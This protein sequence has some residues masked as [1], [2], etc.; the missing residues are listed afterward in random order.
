MP[1]DAN[2]A[3]WSF[4]YATLSF[5]WIVCN[6]AA[7]ELF[8]IISFYGAT[9]ALQWS[10]GLELP[11]TSQRILCFSARTLSFYS[12]CWEIEN[13]NHQIQSTSSIPV[14][15]LFGDNEP[16]RA[17]RVNGASSRTILNR[18][19]T[20][21]GPYMDAAAG[22]ADQNAWVSTLLKM[23]HDDKH[24]GIRQDQSHKKSKLTDYTANVM[25]I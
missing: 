19:T 12:C 15:L 14:E 8:S 2:A 3:Q 9:V 20:T 7:S 25:S 23:T 11:V 22:A 21:T 18:D 1:T 6:A 10:R 24:A 16:E 5:H 4:F 13:T 17:H